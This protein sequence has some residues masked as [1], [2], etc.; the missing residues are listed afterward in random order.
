[1]RLPGRTNP[2]SGVGSPTKIGFAAREAAARNPRA[3]RPPLLGR[4]RFSP[5]STTTAGPT[6]RSKMAPPPVDYSIYFVTGREL[7]PADQ[8]YL[9]NLEAALQGGV[10]IVQV[11]EKNVSTRE[12]LQI[13]KDS[14]ELCDKVSHSWVDW[15]MA[16]PDLT[17]HRLVLPAEVGRAEPH[18]RTQN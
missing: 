11:R 15:K 14:K 6:D 17:R 2:P 1:M 8:T 13:A 12:F 3:K 7:V 16:R 4:V 18:P 5:C 10:T 9:A